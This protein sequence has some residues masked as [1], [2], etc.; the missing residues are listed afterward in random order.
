M[1][2]T[3]SFILNANKGCTK[4]VS[5]VLV[6]RVCR[7]N[8]IV[9]TSRGSW[10]WAHTVNLRYARDITHEDIWNVLQTRVCVHARTCHTDAYKMKINLFICDTDIC[11]R[12]YACMCLYLCRY[13]SL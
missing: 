5:A 7:G 9:I 1:I 11:L 10:I 12:T 6:L 4:I 13:V 8:V 3:L 2:Q